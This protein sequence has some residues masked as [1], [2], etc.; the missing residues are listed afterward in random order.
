MKH[1]LLLILVLSCTRIFAQES[2]VLDSAKIDFE[3]QPIYINYLQINKIDKGL[4]I[5]KSIPPPYYLF[6][7]DNFSFA[8]TF[9]RQNENKIKLLLEQI[10]FYQFKDSLEDS[11]VK[12]LNY[13]VEQS[14]QRIANY[15]SGYEESQNINK[16]LS[17][18]LNE[19]LE[20]NKDG[21][22]SARKEKLKYLIWGAL[23]G[24]LVGTYIGFRSV[25]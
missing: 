11:K 4:R 5:L 12:T 15:K 13:I 2:I 20:I 23:G 10:Q 18:M 16:E 3:G 21:L 8:A 7:E 24:G 17:R 9:F 25:H 14:N 19:S 1:T 6:N 22:K